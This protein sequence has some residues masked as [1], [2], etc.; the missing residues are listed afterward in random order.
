MRVGHNPA[1]SL[2]TVRKPARITV[3]LLTYVPYTHGYYA[4][5][6]DVFRATL[7]SLWRHTPEADVEVLVFDNGSGPE[8]RAYLLEQH[9]AGR[10]HYLILSRENLGVVGAWNIAFQAAPGQVIAYADGDVF[11]RPGWLSESLRI[12]ETFPRVGMVTARPFAAAAELWTATRAWAERD[13]EAEAE[14]GRFIPWDV[15]R[16]FNVGLGQDEAQVRA[17]YE[18][19]R[20]L[21]IRYRGV[22]AIAGASHWQFVAYKRVLQEVL[23]LDYSRPM[24]SDVRNLDRALNERGYLRLMTPKPLVDHMGN[25]LP[26]YA[27]ALLGQDAAPT[28]PARQRSWLAR[29]AQRRPFRTALLWMHDRIF[30]WLYAPPQEGSDA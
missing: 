6:L 29:W 12:L 17:A 28:R 16:E 13:P 20:V 10:I 1:K 8:M 7:T 2:T 14:W 30:E 19:L 18:R 21:R 9:R 22:T 5:S 3:V 23:P 15:F 4:Q 26:P 11:F 24:G 25:T 27:R